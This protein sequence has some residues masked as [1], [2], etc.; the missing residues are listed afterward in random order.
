MSEWL[1]KGASQGDANCQFTLGVMALNQRDYDGAMRWLLKAAAQS[2]T[3]SQDKIGLMYRDGLGV[4]QDNVQA[5][6]WFT[7]AANISGQYFT[8]LRDTLGLKMSPTE[9][10]EA[11]RR[12]AEWKPAK[13]KSR[14]PDE[15][16]GLLT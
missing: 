15:P 14:A 12:A 13:K 16:E 2:H 3:A 10:E 8:P 11:K 4:P 7:L 5:Y 1:F 9:I 6:M